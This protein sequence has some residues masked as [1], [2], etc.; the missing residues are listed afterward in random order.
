MRKS[1]SKIIRD[2]E[3]RINRLENKSSRRHKSAKLTLEK[4]LRE[5]NDHLRAIN[6]MIKAYEEFEDLQITFGAFFS[7][8]LASY[9]GN[10]FST[11]KQYK[12][13]D[14]INFFEGSDELDGFSDLLEKT[15]KAIEEEIKELK[16][17]PP[18]YV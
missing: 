10:T 1:A 2:L 6:K 15:K 11:D 7:Q 13:Y 12:F 16:R 9:I 4:E 14:G 18:V 3:T 5:L 8:D 17:N